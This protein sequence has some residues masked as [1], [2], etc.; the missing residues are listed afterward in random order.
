MD[1]EVLLSVVPEANHRADRNPDRLEP[2]AGRLKLRRRQ[3]P[4]TP[5]KPT[6]CDMPADRQE[7]YNLPTLLIINY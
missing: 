2:A 6:F 1:A 5:K 3:S 7:L 4:P